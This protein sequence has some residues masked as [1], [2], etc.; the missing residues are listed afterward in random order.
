MLAINPNIP[1]ESRTYVRIEKMNPM[2]PE[3]ALPGSIIK[4]V[5]SV[6]IINNPPTIP[7]TQ[8]SCI[9]S[10]LYRLDK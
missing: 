1:D 10:R 8:E 2:L 9:L 5:I 6:I 3:N 4:V 7:I